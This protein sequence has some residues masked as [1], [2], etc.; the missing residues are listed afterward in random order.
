MLNIF[1]SCSNL[2]SI[3]IP[4]SVVTIGWH[5]FYGCDKLTSAIFHCKE[6]RGGISGL[7][8]LSNVVIGEE[9]EIIGESAFSGCTGLTEITI[10]SSVTSIGYSAFSGCTGLTEINIPSSVTSIGNSAFAGCTNLASIYLPESLASIEFGAFENTAWYNSQPDGLVYIG[11]VAYRYKGVMPMNTELIIKEGTLGI[12]GGA[13]SGCQGLTSIFIPNTV[14]NIGSGVFGGCNNL[15]EIEI[16]NS[17]KT[18]GGT[19]TFYSCES[20]TKVIIPNCEIKYIWEDYLFNYCKNIEYLSLNCNN[21]D[22]LFNPYDSKKLKH[23]VLGDHVETI[24][25]GAFASCRQIT[26]LTIGKSVSE[27]KENAFTG[28]QKLDEV[29]CYA[30]NVPKTDRTVFANSFIEYATLYVPA[31]SVEAYKSSAPWSGFKQ[32][33]PLKS[34][35]PDDAERCATPTIIYKDRKLSF[36][37]ATDG[38][39]F[40]TDIT[41]TDI[42]KHY[43][44]TIPL[45]ATYTINVYASKKGYKDSEIATPTL[46]WIDAT[47]QTEGIANNVANIQAR[48]VLIQSSN[49][50]FTIEGA[51]AGTAI[52]VYDTSGKLVGS[53]NAS[54]E[55][56]TTINTS[57]RNGDIGIV[58]IGEKAIKVVMK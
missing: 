18:M 56:A 42:K 7:T 10:P 47:P 21:I 27:I 48:A 51:E 32:I 29:I 30:E 46:C 9:V 20:L 19:Q 6:I 43:T 55:A 40:V 16:P 5:A 15:K 36:E 13:I 17:V 38:V 25:A 31:S 45:T 33:L 49:N 53:A 54:G 4:S 14:V 23:V 11:N 52:S 3:T 26:Q 8:N 24:G 44:A 57:L 34:D 37:C 1:N 12:A 22:N 41:D 2:T 28:I 35:T 58:K 39:T 50:T